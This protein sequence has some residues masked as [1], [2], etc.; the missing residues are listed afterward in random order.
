MQTRFRICFF[1]ISI[2]ILTGACAPTQTRPPL[3]TPEIAPSG[4]I[5]S[6]EADLFY[7][8]I[9][10]G[11]PI[12]VLHGGPGMDHK[13]FLPHL[14]NLGNTF[15]FIFFDQRICGKS[16]WDLD[17]TSINMS[18]F[19]KDI[20]AVRKHFQL[21]KINLLGHSWGGLLAMW[22]ATQQ[23]PLLPSKKFRNIFKDHTSAFLK[24]PD[25]S[26]LSRVKQL[27][28]KV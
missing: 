6:Q 19:V 23:L 12:F 21:E 20:E 13:Y 10:S 24:T 17:S 22:Y 2:G 3:S 5:K 27:L 8:V 14:E 4:I 16:S 15:Q 1:F 18:S 26:P 11:T 9:G 7:K 28:K 25:T